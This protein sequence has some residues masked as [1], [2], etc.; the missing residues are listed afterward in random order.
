[1]SENVRASA[2][3]S[4]AMVDEVTAV[5]LP[6][7]G[8]AQAVVPLADASPEAGEEIRSRMAEIDM[9]DTNSIVSFGSHA[10]AELQ[11]ISKAML[12]GVRNKDVG[13]AGDSL[14]DMVT[15]IRGFSVNELDVRRKRSWWEKLLGKAAPFARF[16]ARYEEVQSQIDRITDNLL[17]HEHV[18]LKDIRSLDMLYDKTLSFYDELALYIAA[19]EAKLAEL[20]A[21][22]IPAKDAEVHAAPEND[23]VMKAQELRDL[24]AARDDL[25]R[26]VHDLKLTRQV[27][28]QSLPSIRLVQEN[29][30]SLVTK[31]NSTLVNTVPLWETQLAQAVTVQR[32]SEAAAAVRE[33]NDLTNDL[34]TSNAANLRESNTAIRTEMERGVFD[35]EAVKQA[36]AD[37]IATIQESLAIADEGKAR[38]ARAEDDL[39]KM[40]HDLRDTL[41]SAKARQDGVGDTAGTAVPGA[42]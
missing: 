19:G 11:E 6:E 20:D 22:D 9:D 40:E 15:S 7:P 36:N 18:L 1:M 23:Q 24:R 8:D 13:P 4:V 30:K 3:Q 37:L 10:Q 32:S 42:A 5:I 2:A 35:I 41:A 25:E 17:K 34:L 38:R 39:K 21:V 14:R 16:T 31:I 29:D 28:M 33:A 27:T 12:D 26:R